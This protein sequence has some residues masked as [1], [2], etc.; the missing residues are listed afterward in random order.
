[1]EKLRLGDARKILE[2]EKEE[3]IASSKLSPRMTALLMQDGLAMLKS[4]GRRCE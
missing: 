4:S 2:M 3:E 1:M